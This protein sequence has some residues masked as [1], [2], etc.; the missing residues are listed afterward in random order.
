MYND[1]WNEH[2]KRAYIIRENVLL[3]TLLLKNRNNPCNVNRMMS[4]GKLKV[5]M[6]IMF[7]GIEVEILTIHVE[8]SP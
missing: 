1:T 7:V 5:T 2:I 8:I 6:V 4:Y 3:N